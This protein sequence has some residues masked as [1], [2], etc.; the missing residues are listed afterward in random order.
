MPLGAILKVDDGAKVV[1][2]E[3]IFTWDPYTNPIIADV[4]GTIGYTCTG[5]Y[6]VRRTGEGTMPAPTGDP[7]HGWSGEIE[8]D[9]LPWGVNPARGFLVT[10]NNRVHDAAYP[11]LIGHDF[12]VAHRA[13]RIADVLAAA[14]GHDVASTVALQI[15]TV[16][17]T[18]REIVDALADSADFRFDEDD[19]V[20]LKGL[21]G[22]HRLWTV[23]EVA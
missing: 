3:V 19:R 21:P 2:D 13:G 11:H 8:A 6:P 23:V 12:H 1:R 15:D 14:E 17:V 22:H 9:D 16:S 20:E 10:A 7:T 18:A 4:E 5:V